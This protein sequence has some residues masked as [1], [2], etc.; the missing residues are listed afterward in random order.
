MLNIETTSR[1]VV[2]KVYI[3]PRAAGNQVAGCRE[4]A[5]KIRLTAPPVDGK[6]NRA[7]LKFLAGRLKV[8]KSDIEIISGTAGRSKKILVNIPEK[9]NREQTAESI[10]KRIENLADKKGA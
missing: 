6:A 5:L 7:C 9:K 8:P 3:Q 10:K 1:G 4:D 2:F